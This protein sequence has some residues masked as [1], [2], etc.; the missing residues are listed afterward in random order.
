MSVDRPPESGTPSALLIEQEHQPPTLLQAAITAMRSPLLLT[1]ASTMGEALADLENGRRDLILFNAHLP[2]AELPEVVAQLRAVAPEAALVAYGGDGGG[3]DAALEAGLQDWLPLRHEDVG[4]VSRVLSHALLRTRRMRKLIHLARHDEVTGLANTMQFRERLHDLLA[5]SSRD[6]GKAALLLVDVDSYRT[7]NTHLRPSQLDQLLRQVAARLRALFRDSD[8]VAR[9]AGTEFGVLVNGI[10]SVPG[11]VALARQVVDLLRQPIFASQQEMQ[12]HPSAG[13][14]THPQAGRDCDSLMKHAYAALQEAKR[15]GSSGFSLFTAEMA[16]RAR[17][18]DL[19]IHSLRDAIER[20][21][22]FLVYQPQVDLRTGRV[23]G[24]ES[25]LR[26]D[27]PALGVVPPGQFIPLLEDTGLILP[28]S[29]WVLRSACAQNKS[30]RRAGLPPI[31]VTVNLSAT[32]FRQAG[33]V[34]SV[35]AALQEAQLEAHALDLELT[36]GLLMENTP[37]TI[38]TLRQLKAMGVRISV[39][40]FG[41]GYSSLSY[42]KRFPLDTLKIDRSF[43]GDLMNDAMDATLSRAIIHLAHNLGLNV[44]AEGVENMA[45]LNFLQEEGCDEAQGYLFGKPM[46]ADAMR[47]LLLAGK[48]LLTP[49]GG[50]RLQLVS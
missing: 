41:T 34:E 36:E 15:A 6:F 47:E 39:D 16:A 46:G 49:A 31:R 45:Q 9:L 29:H 21:Q 20:D 42:L 19:L 24:A 18:H 33:L 44:V 4:A 8:L 25:L 3:A 30:W 12:L 48:P 5:H 13:L 50:R 1:R 32:Q 7:L 43:V 40:D 22:F 28:V 37:S 11:I 14:A 17:E 35:A 27:H 26:W 23:V 38:G 10:T 2:D